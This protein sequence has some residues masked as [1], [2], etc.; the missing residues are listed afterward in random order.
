LL[1]YSTDAG[2]K[3]VL[4]I[5]MSS[6]PG[7]KAAWSE[8]VTTGVPD[9]A[10]RAQ[11]AGV[12]TTRA[13]SGPW[14]ASRGLPGREGLIVMVTEPPPTVPGSAGGAGHDA[15]A[16]WQARPGRRGRARPPATGAGA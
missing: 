5:T 10:R 14:R 3:G 15:H 2:G 16:S 13:S 12:P 11:V 7:R 1:S 6:S 4:S 8:P 9:R